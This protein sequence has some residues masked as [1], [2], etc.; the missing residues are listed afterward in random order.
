MKTYTKSDLKTYIKSMHNK[1]PSLFRGDFISIETDILSKVTNAQQIT[2]LNLDTLLNG[3]D[4]APNNLETSN[5][6]AFLAELRT[7]YWLSDLGFTNIYPIKAKKKISQPDFIAKY[8]NHNAIIDAYCMTFTNQQKPDPVLNV[9]INSHDKLLQTIKSK[10]NEEK[11]P[12]LNILTSQIEIFLCVINSEPIKNT[13]DTYDFKNYLEQVYND[14]S[15][16]LPYYL[17]ICTGTDDCIY[18]SLQ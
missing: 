1:R 4:F 18:P 12:Q 16:E 13:N 3:L 17:G 14:L 9:F 7:I 2:S 10:F 6:E 5:F 11:K 15:L 8:K